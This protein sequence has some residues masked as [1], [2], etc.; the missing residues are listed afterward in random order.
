VAPQAVDAKMVLEGV[1]VYVIWE[2]RDSD[3][4]A[5]RLQAL[6]GPEFGLKMM[7]SRG[8]KVWPD[9]QAETYRGD[10]FRCRLLAANGRT[11]SYD[12]VVS[13]LGRIAGAGLKFAKTESLHSFDGE[14]GYTLGQGE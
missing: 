9:G 11:A 8:T 13:V 12:D 1:D 10:Q 2:S 6:A 4:L 3:A 14:R 7:T 5:S